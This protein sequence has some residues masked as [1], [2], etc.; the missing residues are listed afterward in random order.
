MKCEYCSN[1]AEYEFVEGTLV[2]VCGK[3]L[4]TII[5]KSARPYFKRIRSAVYF[6]HRK[7]WE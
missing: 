4:R 2:R 1:H 6:D 3:C 7:L 5:N